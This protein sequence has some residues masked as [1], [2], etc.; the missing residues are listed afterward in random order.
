MSNFSS[1]S[2]LSHLRRK[3]NFRNLHENEEIYWLSKEATQRVRDT[4][5]SRK[6]SLIWKSGDVC[7][8][9]IH[10]RQVVTVS[11]ES[12]HS[13]LVGSANSFFDFAYSSP[14]RRYSYAG[15]F[16]SWIIYEVEMIFNLAGFNWFF[17]K[18][19]YSFSFKNYTGKLKWRRNWFLIITALSYRIAGIFRNNFM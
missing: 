5:C 19:N 17:L 9:S 16:S 3:I 1:N 14:M 8:T 10:M 15:I 6:S 4:N 18:F 12:K 11:D 7:T 2:I 13:T